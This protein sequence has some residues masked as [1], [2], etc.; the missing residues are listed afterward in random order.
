MFSYLA[1]PCDTSLALLPTNSDLSTRFSE[2]ELQDLVAC[3]ATVTRAH[4]ADLVKQGRCS[5]WVELSPARISGPHYYLGIPEDL[6]DMPPL[7]AA[8][9]AMYLAAPFFANTK[10][11]TIDGDIEGFLMHDLACYTNVRQLHLDG[12]APVLFE[13]ALREGQP[14]ANELFPECT[15]VSIYGFNFVKWPGMTVNGCPVPEALEARLLEMLNEWRADAKEPLGIV[16]EK[17]TM[18]NHTEAVFK[19]IFGANYVNVL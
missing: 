4:F 16:F 15:E 19:S 7:R 1:F 5:Q 8:T 13:A 12:V 17:C 11:L 14:P 18:G 10:T 3:A 6:L 2:H 9:A